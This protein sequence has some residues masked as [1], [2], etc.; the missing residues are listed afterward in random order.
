MSDEQIIRSVRR[1]ATTG[2]PNSS[3][4]N[5]FYGPNH[6][7]S[8][9]LVPIN[10]DHF[11]YAFFTKANMNLSKRYL[12]H[13]RKLQYL[14]DQ[15]PNSVATAVKC[16]LSTK[17]GWNVERDGVRSN[18]INDDYPF[19]PFLS[20]SLVSI[21]GWP[22]EAMEFFESEEGWAKEVHGYADGKPDNYRSFD[23]TFTWDSKIGDPH[24]LYLS[25]MQQYMGRVGKGEIKA[26]PTS[27]SEFETDY[28]TNVY[29]IITDKSKRFIQKI[30]RL[31]GGGLWQ[32]VPS[33]QDFN[34]DRESNMQLEGRQVSAPMKCFGFYYNDPI[35]IESFNR[36]VFDFNVKMEFV[37]YGAGDEAGMVQIQPHQKAIFNNRG[38]PYINPE[39]SELEWWIEREIYNDILNIE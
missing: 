13:V 33:G 19:I 26:S 18:A 1:Q 34:V 25:I 6:F 24:K 37:S 9:D 16:C 2:D 31:G 30:A 27:I 5:F 39:T 23:L 17:H 38:Y 7:G 20:S 35:I 8:T 29:I 21:S 36:L 10:Q 14:L 22:D 3:I 15:D 28:F 11:A 12:A 32:G 4:F